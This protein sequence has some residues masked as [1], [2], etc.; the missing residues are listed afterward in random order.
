MRPLEAGH[1]VFPE[2]NKVCMYAEHQIHGDWALR[3]GETAFGKK[4][5]KIIGI[6]SIFLIGF[7][8]L[9]QRR[10]KETHWAW[11]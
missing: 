4:R 1:F 6:E 8:C 7:M 11:A 5:L 3:N 10:E 9:P 2:Q